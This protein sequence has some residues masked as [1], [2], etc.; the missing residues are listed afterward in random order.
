MAVF[1][2]MW[3]DKKG[4]VET[5]E[6]FRFRVQVRGRR[7]YGDTG[8]TRRPDAEAFERDR[9]RSI[10]A[11]ETMTGLFR[12]HRD[13]LAGTS[14][15][16]LGDAWEIYRRKPRRRPMGK[17]REQATASRWHDFV[18]FMAE[19][20][21][22]VTTMIAVQR[23]HADEY[24]HRI[25]TEGRWN[26]TVLFRPEG[27]R[28][29]VTYAA[30]LEHLSANTKNDFLQTCKSVFDHLAE[31]A[32]LPENPFGRIKKLYRDQ[33]KRQPFSPEELQ[34]IGHTADPDMYSLFLV[35]MT[36]GM[37][38][39]DICLLRW[40]QID[41]GKRELRIRTEK[42]GVTVDLPILPGLYDHL[43]DAMDRAAAGERYVFPQLAEMYR[44]NASGISYRVKKLLGDLAIKNLAAPKGRSRSVSTKDVHSL[45]HTFVYLAGLNNVPLPIV[46][47]VV[48]HMTGDMTKLYMAHATRE[49]VRREL[50]KLPNY[51][52]DAPLPA[53]SR[54]A[55]LE[56]ATP[57][58]AL[59]AILDGMTSDN[60]QERAAELRRAITGR[61]HPDALQLPGPATAVP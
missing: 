39:G 52:I 55:D 47:A 48:G 56:K 41:M 51:L 33:E 11:E 6:T 53:I 16:S 35:A 8:C 14:Q 18:E 2:P 27:R 61:R 10:I 46:Q 36:T 59:L 1:K 30:T 3:K 29:T 57:E 17:A 49:D 21:P 15:L 31:D 19:R 23:H 22:D 24:V 26:K 25:R 42:T 5:A 12:V 37:R 34:A 45:R 20:H 50:A 4:H 54:H 43:R 38:R 44:T 13:N 40:D 7:Y 60:W 28:K 32:A 9:V 58:D